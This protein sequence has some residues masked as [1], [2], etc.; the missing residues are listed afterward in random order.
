MRKLTVLGRCFIAV[1]ML[2]FGIQHVVYLDFVTRAFPAL[3]QVIPAH[4]ALAC[5]FGAFLC[6]A[7]LAM[8]L[9]IR[10]R[11]SA[12]LLGTAI[13]VMFAVFLLP[14]LL[15]SLGNVIVWINS[16]KALVLAGASFIVAGSV[17]GTAGS[18]YVNRPG[19]GIM[20]WVNFRCNNAITISR[21]YSPGATVEKRSP[22]PF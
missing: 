14:V 22:M 9:G 16:G 8:A 6:A 4:A 19:T 3:P 15:G 12:L 2:A 18:A 7:G 1:A 5:V 17:P 13:L 10:A 21:L 11:E 20:Q